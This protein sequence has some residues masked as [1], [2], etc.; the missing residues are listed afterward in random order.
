[1]KPAWWLA[2][3]LL[4]L[5]GICRPQTPLFA[6]GAEARLERGFGGRNL[7]WVLLDGQGHLAA[8]HWDE[9]ERAVPPGSMVKPFTALAFGE[10]HGGEFPQVLCRGARGRCWLPK[11]HGRLGL[12]EA[13]AQSC[14]DYFVTLA[15]EVDRAQAERVFA[16]YGLAGP[17]EGARAEG[18]A[19]LSEDW[20]ERPEA[21]ARAFWQL[22]GERK[23]PIQGR[24]VEGMRGSANHGTARAVD[25]ALGA[26]AA[27]AKTGTAACTHRPRGAVDGFVVVLYPAD[28]PRL[29]LLVRAHGLTGAGTAKVAGQ[30]L[31]E[32]GMG[33]D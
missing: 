18:F 17:A 19:G 16:R 6:Q 10:E 31:R 21:L 32:L 29:L 23:S 11:G 13:I 4:L 30:M 8:E 33:N 26:D 7:S 28:Q 24:I 9:A 3:G 5:P 20:R 15:G 12:E 1:L 27:L 25:E 14:N 22:A 2:V